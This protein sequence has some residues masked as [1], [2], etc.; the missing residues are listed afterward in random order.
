MTTFYEKGIY[1]ELG[2]TIA[3]ALKE[4]GCKFEVNLD[5][6]TYTFINCPTDV[7][8]KILKIKELKGEVSVL[9]EFIPPDQW[10]SPENTYSALIKTSSKH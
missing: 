1:N 4:N 7:V 10:T 5:N 3:H 2:A 8:N 6:L 9:N